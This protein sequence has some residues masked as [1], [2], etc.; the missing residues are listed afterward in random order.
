MKKIELAEHNF[1]L[2]AQF[3]LIQILGDI[4]AR[5]P[6]HSLGHFLNEVHEKI[7]SEKIKLVKVDVRKLGFINSVGIKE[8]T[9]WIAKVDQLTEAQVYKIQ[10]LLDKNIQWQKN[11]FTALK[12]LSEKNIE[13]A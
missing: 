1:V 6:R 7:I 11:T 2:K 8:F 4:D 9:N 13:L 10:F 3:D 12:W 5:D